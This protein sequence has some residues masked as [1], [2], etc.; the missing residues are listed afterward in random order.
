M[1]DR[2]A[3]APE[4][5]AQRSNVGRLA[6]L[7]GALVPVILVVLYFLHSA[8]LVD[9]SEYS[10]IL[11]AVEVEAVGPAEDLIRVYFTDPKYPDI[12]EDRRGG[13]DLILAAD[14]SEARSS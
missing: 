6:A 7:A 9:L 2:E 5:P 8:G 10:E 13:L 1:A 12:K 4:E 14:I 3:L 11:E